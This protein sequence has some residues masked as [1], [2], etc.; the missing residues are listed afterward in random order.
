MEKRMISF[1]PPDISELEIAEVAEA[2]RSGWIT[3][4]PRVKLLER[5]LAAYIETGDTTVDTEQNKEYYSNRVVCLNSATAAEELNLR[6]LGIQPG[7]EVIVPAYTYTATASAAIHC[8]A[9][10]KFVDIQK[11]GDNVTHAPEMDYEKLEVAI[12]E[13]TKAIVPVDLGGIVCDYDKIFEIVE[14]KKGLFKAVESDGSPLKDLNHRIQSAIGRVAIVS[15]CAHSLGA[16]RVVGGQK[17]F[18]GAI[19]DFSS[20]SFHAVKNFTT[21]EGGAATWR[22]ITGV[23]N[24]EI[25]KF[26]QL[27]SLH[28]QNK[29]ALAKT[30]IGCWEYDIIGAWYKCNMT[31]IMAAIGLKQLDRYKAMLNRRNEIIKKYDKTCD[32]LGIGHLVHHTD[33]M[34]SSNHL[35]LTRIPDISEEQRNALIVKF[36]EAGVATNVHYKP[37]PMMT[38]YKN[39]TVNFSNSYDYYHNLI[40]LPLHTMLTDDEVEYVCDV[41]KKVVGKQANTSKD[42]SRSIYSVHSISDTNIQ[43]KVF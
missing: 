11:D 36:A 35:Y 2:L 20:F 22:A 31:D 9:T 1:S 7:D 14:R 25:Y 28:G 23:D 40:T 10:V 30:K 32:E 29:D 3:T 16:S 38:A 26:Y 37:L 15:D 5:R 18:C 4:G 41:M 6:I 19:A 12:T 34:D 33:V 24:A 42:C 21:A 8:G 13:K 43:Q 17:L 27:L 39:S